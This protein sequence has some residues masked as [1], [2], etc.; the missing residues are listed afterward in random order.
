MAKNLS[1]YQSEVDGYQNTAAQSCCTPRVQQK[2]LRCPQDFQSHASQPR[3]ST[4]SS[5]WDLLS[6]LLIHWFFFHVEAM[7]RICSGSTSALACCL[8]NPK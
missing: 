1:W 5:L 2:T 4:V 3:H 8:V 7:A 6:Q